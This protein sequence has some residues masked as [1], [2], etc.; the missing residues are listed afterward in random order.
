MK[1]VVNVGI[2]GRSFAIDED[3]YDK[4]KR[5]LDSFRTQSKIGVQSKE[6]MDDLEERISELFAENTTSFKN[7]V[8]I[9]LVDRVIAQLG[10]PDG[11]QYVEGG[12]AEG[13]DPIKD[14]F[15]GG[16][17]IKRFYRNPDNKSIAGVASGI[18]AYINI[19]PLLVRILF[20]IAL[21][22]GSAGF[23]IYIIMW[24]AAPLAKTPA[25]KCEMFGLPVTAENMRKFSTTK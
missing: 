14:F 6:V 15:S 18:A 19:D 24:I 17:P 12:D 5:Y 21:L 22:M 9:A 2:G 11:E 25:Q 10:M 13:G 1:K 7:V 8:D 20:I 23:W 3:A 4:L 16:K